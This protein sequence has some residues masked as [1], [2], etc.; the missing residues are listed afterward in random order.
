M[1]GD[2]GLLRVYSSYDGEVTGVEQCRDGMRD[3]SL[4][5]GELQKPEASGNELPEGVGYPRS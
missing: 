5:M 1:F 3:S 4:C 2:S